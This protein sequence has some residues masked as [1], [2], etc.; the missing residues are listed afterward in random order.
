MSSFFILSFS[1]VFQVPASANR[2]IRLYPCSCHRVVRDLCHLNWSAL[3]QKTLLKCDTA[4]Y[5]YCQKFSQSTEPRVCVLFKLFV[6]SQTPENIICFS[7]Q[8][9]DKCADLAPRQPAIQNKNPPSVLWSSPLPPPLH[10]P[11]LLSVEAKDRHWA[12]GGQALAQ[13]SNH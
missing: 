7:F 10:L 9:L 12:G 2:C 1:C 13:L 6:L 3:S 4:R 11:L 8:R 5:S